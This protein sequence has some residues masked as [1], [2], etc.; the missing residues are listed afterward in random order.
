MVS[1]DKYLSKCTNYTNDII[2]IL[3][4]LVIVI[5][6]KVW[7][8]IILE[9]LYNNGIS[10]LTIGIISAIIVFSAVCYL[11]LEFIRKKSS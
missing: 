11:D 3:I 1:V 2:G 10:K 6:S 4:F 8:Q 9:Y 7:S 5:F